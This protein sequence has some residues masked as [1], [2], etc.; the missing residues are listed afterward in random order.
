MRNNF[1]K[2]SGKATCLPKGITLQDNQLLSGYQ[3][4]AG[5]RDILFPEGEEGRPP[6]DLAPWNLASLLRGTYSAVLHRGS[7]VWLGLALS[8]DSPL[9]QNHISKNRLSQSQVSL[10][11]N[12]I[13]G[14]L[15]QLGTRFC[16]Q[17]EF[18]FGHQ[19]LPQTKGRTKYRK[20]I[21]EGAAFCEFDPD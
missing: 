9:G 14:F 6:N 15:E 10:P 5:S 12:S 21:E 19:L 8:N 1:R 4:N 3:K 13:P 20:E 17:T 18:T 16:N 2:E 7:R 11:S